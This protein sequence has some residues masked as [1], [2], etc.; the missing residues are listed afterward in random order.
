MAGIVAT[1]LVLA[2][3][4]LGVVLWLNRSHPPGDKISV[5]KQPS[6]LAQHVGASLDITLWNIG[7]AGLGRL[8][9]FVTDGGNSRFPPSSNAV[10]DNLDAIVETLS[11]TPA[12]I[13]LLQEVSDK[14][15]LSYWHPVRARIVE[16]L[17]EQVAFFRSDVS[18]WGLPWPLRIVHGT[19]T[20]SNAAP[21]STQMVKLPAEPTFLGGII[22]RNYGLLVT[23]FAIANSPTNW[24][25]VNLHLAAF[26]PE[27]ATRHKQLEAVLAFA[28][29]EYEKGNHVVLGGDWNLRLHKRE[30]PH[31]TDLKQLFWL[32]DL[33]EEKLPPGWQIA[34]DKTLPTVRTN[35]QPYVKGENYTAIIDGF[36]VSPNVAIIK[37]TTTDTGF[38]HTD[39]MPVSASFSTKLQE[40]LK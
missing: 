29:T 22:K 39:H 11:E 19:L 38:E 1:M 3:A 14:S 10:T 20:L 26:D 5:L 34:C 32:V 24:V 6:G 12:D 23:R 18:S 35:Y 37:V 15:P 2:L 8:S 33:P 36:I 17:P 7:Y 28:K 4:Y 30:F 9:D 27:G 31:T 21:T 16:S 25:V 13:F 40:G